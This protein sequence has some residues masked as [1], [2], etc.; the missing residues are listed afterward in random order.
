MKLKQLVIIT[1]GMVILL[2]PA[3][4][5]FDAQILETSQYKWGPFNQSYYNTFVVIKPAT[6]SSEALQIT[7]DS[8]GNFTLANRSGRVFFNQSFT[9][10]TDSDSPSSAIIGA[11]R[12]VVSFTMPFLV[13]IF[14]VNSST[15]PG[16]GMTFLIAP[17]LTLPQGSNGQYLSLTNV[18]SNGNPN[19]HL[20]LVELDTFSF[21]I[22]Y[23]SFN[24][25]NTKIPFYPCI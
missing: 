11:P 6:I 10:W 18:A 25:F 5:F 3:S 22:F 20:L 9:L 1:F 4:T 16:E 7:P 14:R 24:Q 19:N 13:N 23:S 15:V 21:L 2:F 8:T 12:R 17:N